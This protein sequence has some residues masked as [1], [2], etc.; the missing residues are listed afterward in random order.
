M[1]EATRREKSPLRDGSEAQ[2]IGG[3]IHVDRLED[4]LHTWVVGSDWHRI[5]LGYGLDEGLTNLDHL[6]VGRARAEPTQG[7]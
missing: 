6:V 2:G 5:P 4:S 1:P 7:F 3:K